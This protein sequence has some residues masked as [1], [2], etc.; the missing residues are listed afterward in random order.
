VPP[1]IVFACSRKI[2][3]TNLRYNKRLISVSLKEMFTAVGALGV[4]SFIQRKRDNLTIMQ[5]TGE[6]KK[7]SLRENL[8]RKIWL[9]L[10]LAPTG[11]ACLEQSLIKHTV[12]KIYIE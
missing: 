3:K 9:S 6:V 4:Y 1:S 2:K 11:I 12:M 7:L 10:K 8:L 5:L